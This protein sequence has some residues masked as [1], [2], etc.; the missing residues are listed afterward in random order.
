M[1]V[2]VLDLVPLQLMKNYLNTYQVRNI[3]LEQ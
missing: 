3:P 2:E 1:E